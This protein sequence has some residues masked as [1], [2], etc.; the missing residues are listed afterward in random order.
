MPIVRHSAYCKYSRTQ[1]DGNSASID[2]SVITQE[3]KG[4]GASTLILL[5][6]ANWPHMART[7]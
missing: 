2:A 5:A 4:G 1:V 3:G 7:G 6:K